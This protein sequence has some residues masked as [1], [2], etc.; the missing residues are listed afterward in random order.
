MKNLVL[1]LLFISL[2]FYGCI[3][4]TKVISSNDG[5]PIDKGTYIDHGTY[6]EFKN[7][8][9]NSIH[10]IYWNSDYF[11]YQAPTTSTSV[12]IL[13]KDVNIFYATN[14]SNVIY[15]VYDCGGTQAG[16]NLYFAMCGQI[17]KNSVINIEIDGVNQFSLDFSTL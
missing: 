13:G 15:N 11:V 10:Y 7:K 5:Y 6:I 1:S 9:P 3:G 17:E 14:Q 2:F 4:S 16:N 8:V 12:K